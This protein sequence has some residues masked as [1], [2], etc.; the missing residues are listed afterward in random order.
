MWIEK[1]YSSDATIYTGAPPP[2]PPPTEPKIAGY[3]KDAITGNPIG[4]AT[5]TFDVDTVYVD[6]SGYYEIVNPTPMSGRITCSAFG[7][8]TSETWIE[9]PMDGTLTVN[10]NLI[11][12]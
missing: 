2:P 5:I 9:S 10:F 3:V 6:T 8:I 1:S 4:L 7:Y 11:P 12:G